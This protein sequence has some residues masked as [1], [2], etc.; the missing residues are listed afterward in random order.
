MLVTK[1]TSDGRNSIC[2]LP[3]LVKA[4]RLQLSLAD[5]ETQFYEYWT[6]MERMG[7]EMSSMGL[8]KKDHATWGEW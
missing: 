4:K 5:T 6:S 1:T 2:F 8:K 7:T 3:W